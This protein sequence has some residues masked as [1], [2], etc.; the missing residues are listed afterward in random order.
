MLWKEGGRG[1][2][3]LCMHVGLYDAGL[4]CDFFANSVNSNKARMVLL[5]AIPDS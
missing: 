1:A 2:A 4:C 5:P 3:I